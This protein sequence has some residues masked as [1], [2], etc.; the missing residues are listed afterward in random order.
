METNVIARDPETKQPS[1][2]RCGCGARVELDGYDVM[3]G[4]GQP[5]N[6]FG[7]PLRRGHDM[8]CPC[9]ECA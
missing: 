6:G 8:E 1:A 2:I 9:W 4:C 5:F 3:C 7:Q